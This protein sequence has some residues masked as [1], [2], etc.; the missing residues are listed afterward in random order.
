MENNLEEK[1]GAILNN[2]DMMQ[3][4]QEMA[5]SLGQSP[6][7]EP[8][9]PQNSNVPQ[10]DLTMLQNLSGL[11]GQTGIDTNQ[12]ALLHALSPYIGTGKMTKLEKAMRAAKVARLA[13]GFLGN[14]GLKMLTGR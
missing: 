1:L 14:G 6:S 4:I 7:P 8:Q 9:T 12:Q 11:A 3:K 5:R 13:S 10:I 2:P